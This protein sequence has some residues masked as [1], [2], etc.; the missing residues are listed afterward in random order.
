MKTRKKAKPN[1]N[2]S[3]T[4][5]QAKHILQML[6]QQ[7]C[8]EIRKVIE[9]NAARLIV[10]E[11]ITTLRH[12]VDV[13]ITLSEYTGYQPV[14][15]HELLVLEKT[16]FDSRYNRDETVANEVVNSIITH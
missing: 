9:A 4:E 14:V 7:C 3:L 2:L 1:L 12:L 6:S 11:E 8:G 15:Y 10:R 13:I 5:E 16:L